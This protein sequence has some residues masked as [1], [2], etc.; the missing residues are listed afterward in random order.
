M[1][2]LPCLAPTLRGCCVVYQV[3]K[4]VRASSLPHLVN[5]VSQFHCLPLPYR[6]HC[7]APLPFGR[8]VSLHSLKVKLHR[9]SPSWESCWTPS[10]PLSV[11]LLSSFTLPYLPYEWNQSWTWREREWKK[12]RKQRLSKMHNQRKERLRRN[13]IF[14]RNLHRNQ[15]SLFNSIKPLMNLLSLLSLRHLFYWSHC[16]APWKIG[17][18]LSVLVAPFFHSSPWT[19][20]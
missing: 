14:L 20:K 2:C 12:K 11:S 6:F 15:I 8:V 3:H 7:I 1:S 16:L 4:D 19:V 10:P 9:S 13:Q 5:S 17:Y 18:L